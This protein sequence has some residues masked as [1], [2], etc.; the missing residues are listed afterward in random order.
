MLIIWIKIRQI[1]QVRQS[2]SFLTTA[3][4]TIEFSP[5]LIKFVKFENL[6]SKNPSYGIQKK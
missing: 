1:G 4:R 2:G 6:N 5:F 3:G